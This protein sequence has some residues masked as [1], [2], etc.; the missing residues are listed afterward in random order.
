MDPLQL[1]HELERGLE[2][3]QVWNIGGW[4]ANFASHLG[5]AYALA[6]RV[7]EAVPVVE[8]GVGSNVST[9]GMHL[10]WRVYLSEAYLL[11]G[12]REEAS[13]LAGRALELARQHNEQA[14]QAWVLRL[15]G[16]IHAQSDPLG[17]EPAEAAYREALALAEALGMRPLQAHCHLGLGMLHG[18]LGRQKEARRELSTAIK[19]Y[20]TLHGVD[21]KAAKDA[22]E[23]R[24]RELGR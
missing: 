8:Q 2:L 20:R 23:A 17:V 5:Y 15:L 9:A 3:C 18:T 21:L 12:R 14:N 16:D 4:L 24:G 22:V 10:L 6:G 13:W 11:A 7:T 19:M 1:P